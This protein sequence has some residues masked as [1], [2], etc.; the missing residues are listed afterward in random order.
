MAQSEYRA[1]TEHGKRGGFGVNK[2][3]VILANQTLMRKH[4]EELTNKCKP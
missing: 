2:N 1:E 3:S 4:I